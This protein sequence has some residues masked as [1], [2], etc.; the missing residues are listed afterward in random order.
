MPRPKKR[1]QTW[2][3]NLHPVHHRQS[4]VLL[5]PTAAGTEPVLLHEADANGVS[6]NDLEEDAV[7][8]P[9]PEDIEELEP[10]P[11][12]QEEMDVVGS[13]ET[14]QRF[15]E[16]MALARVILAKQDEDLHQQ[17][18]KCHYPGN[19]VR[20]QRRHKQTRKLLQESGTTKSILDFFGRH[21]A[22]RSG[23][24]VSQTHNHLSVY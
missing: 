16:V 10:T 1:N 2:F 22:S 12:V 3:A 11:E 19:S 8:D 24:N 20:S 4:D 23:P 7:L 18:R 9:A 17:K 6:L 15:D 5:P 13:M 14:V 21:E